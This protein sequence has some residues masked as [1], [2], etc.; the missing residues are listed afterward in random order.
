MPQGKAIPSVVHWIVVRLST[1]MSEE[2]IA[3]YTDISIRSVRKI[4]STF[5]LTG[6][7]LAPKSEKP[8]THRSLNNYDVQVRVYL[9]LTC[10]F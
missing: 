8:K 1:T 9:T 2:D 6:S 3:M 4:L 5:R 10:R 7:V